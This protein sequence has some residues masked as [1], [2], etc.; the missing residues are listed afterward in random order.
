MSDF[1]FLVRYKMKE[2]GIESFCFTWLSEELHNED[3][4][5]HLQIPDLEWSEKDSIWRAREV[6]EHSTWRKG[7][8]REVVEI[9]RAERDNYPM[10]N[11]VLLMCEELGCGFGSWSFSHDLVLGSRVYCDAFGSPNERW[12]AEVFDACRDLFP[13]RSGDISDIQNALLADKAEFN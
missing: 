3:K 13:E 2:H 10:H 11:G 6:L 1:V 8:N 5:L 9:W 4:R 12:F 7:M